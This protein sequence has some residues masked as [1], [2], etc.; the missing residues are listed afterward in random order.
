MVD[1]H[2]FVWSNIFKEAA[3]LGLSMT[4]VFE[5]DLWQFLCYIDGY[6]E[7]IEEERIRNVELSVLIGR[8]VGQ[9]FSGKRAPDPKSVIKDI[10]NSMNSNNEDNDADKDAEYEINKLKK[11]LKCFK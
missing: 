5:M 3:I 10:H 4:E 11:Q 9:Y 8:Y 2:G 1:K 7:R 6:N